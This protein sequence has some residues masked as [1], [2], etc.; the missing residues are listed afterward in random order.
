[1]NVIIT[2]GGTGGHIYPA[3]AI[4]KG[5]QETYVGCDILYVGTSK[6]LEAGILPKTGINFRFITVEGLPRKINFQSLKSG[7]KFLKG[8]GQSFKI[9]SEFKPDAIVST[10]GYVA[11]PVA[12]VGSQMGVPLMLHEQNS[13]PGITNKLL[14][15]RAKRI[16]LTFKDSKQYFKDKSKLR[17][18]GLPIRSE[19]LKVS[20]KGSYKRLGLD[21]RMKTVLI[22]GGSRGAWSINNAIAKSMAELIKIKN[23]QFIFITGE[24]SY[25]ETT[26]TIKKQGINLEDMGNITI[27]PY[28][29]NMEDAIGIA[30]LV[31]GRAGATFLAEITALGIPAILVPYPWATENHQEHNARSLVKNGAAILIKDHD[32]TSNNLLKELDNLLLNEKRLLSMKKASQELGEPHAL[33]KILEVFTE[34]VP[35]N[36]LS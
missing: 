31:I 16:C 26:E 25:L 24:A 19:I 34:V 29:H 27:K 3:L 15:R 14:A 18:T 4:A 13:Y 2:G 9:I 1:M 23:T 20:K 17:L 12:W 10:G 5:L 11:G 32:L 7:F 6:G 21:P 33:K 30:D 8:L 28:I 22:T 35:Y 36:L